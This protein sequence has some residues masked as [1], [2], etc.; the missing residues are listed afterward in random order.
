L[1][2]KKPTP[3]TVAVPR[4]GVKMLDDGTPQARM[5]ATLAACIRRRSTGFA[6]RVQ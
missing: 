6:V 2:S 1:K 4:S 3:V 5:N